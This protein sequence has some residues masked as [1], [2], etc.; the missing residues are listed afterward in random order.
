MRHEAIKGARGGF[1]LGH[2]TEADERDG[3]GGVGDEKPQGRG[4]DVGIA[5]GADEVE[6]VGMLGDQ[7]AA[8]G[9]H[10]HDAA[11][12]PAGGGDALA[13]VGEIDRAGAEGDAFDFGMIF[14]QTLDFRP[15]HVGGNAHVADQTL[16]L[17]PEGFAQGPASNAA[18]PIG[19]VHDA[20]DVEEVDAGH[21]ETGE[22]LFEATTKI[23]GGGPGTFGGNVE[24]QGRRRHGPERL[25]ENV[26]AAVVAVVGRGVEVGDAGAAGGMEDGDALLGAL[27]VGQTHAAAADR[28]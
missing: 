20:P 2:G 4:H 7:A 23:G 10:G 17:G 24:G 3:D 25:A 16:V 1:D 21:A 9:V 27:G 22:G 5:G 11:P 13:A 6:H 28:A 12:E 8:E 18:L 15:G 14:Q 26:L 19:W